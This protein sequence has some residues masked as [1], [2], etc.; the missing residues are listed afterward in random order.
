MKKSTEAQEHEEYLN[1]RYNL[2]KAQ[3]AKEVKKESLARPQ[4]ENEALQKLLVSEKQKRENEQKQRT[5]TLEA[6]RNER[7]RLL[8]ERKQEEAKLEAIKRKNHRLEKE[9]RERQKRKT[10]RS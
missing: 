3:N 4:A 6:E 5:E 7:E 8:E 10:K 1:K 2:L 9:E